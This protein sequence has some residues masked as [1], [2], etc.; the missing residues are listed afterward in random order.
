MTGAVIG[1][2]GSGNTYA[3]GLD[4]SQQLSTL[5]PSVKAQMRYRVSNGRNLD[6]SLHTDAFSKQVDPNATIRVDGSDV[7][8]ALNGTGL[9][10]S[11]PVRANLGSLS[12][13][14]AWDCT[15]CRAAM[16]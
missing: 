1:R 14:P 13:S 10:S 12:H 15:R 7:F 11:S 3:L 5:T 6:L 9:I 4:G 8:V 16:S 2:V